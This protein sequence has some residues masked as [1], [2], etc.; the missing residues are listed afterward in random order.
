A[1]KIHQIKKHVLFNSRPS[2]YAKD[3][4]RTWEQ[5]RQAANRTVIK[6]TFLRLVVAQ[7]SV[8]LEKRCLHLRQRPN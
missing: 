5:K 4:L 8:F 7:R 6:S 2:G 3:F 1:V